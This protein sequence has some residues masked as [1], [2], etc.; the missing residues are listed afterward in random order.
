M[1]IADL[2]PPT[3]L[4]TTILKARFGRRRELLRSV[5]VNTAAATIGFDK[6]ANYAVSTFDKR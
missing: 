3:T 6:N 1:Q 4:S 2:P 5:R